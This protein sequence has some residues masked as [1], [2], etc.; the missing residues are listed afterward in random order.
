M[1]LELVPAALVHASELGR[2][3]Y[4]SFK[5]IADRHHFP[6]IFPSVDA[7]RQTIMSLASH[8]AYYGV[9]ALFDGEPAGSAFVSLEDEVA[10]IAPVSVE[11][12]RQGHSIGRAMMQHLI[13]YSRQRGF[14]RI[15]LL[16]EAYNTSSL[17][18]YASLGFDVKDA[19]V[20]MQAAPSPDP[21]EAVR[22][23]T[24]ADVPAVDEL[25]RR[26]YRVSRRQEVADVIARNAPA[27]VRERDSRITGYF[28]P[29]MSGFCV[30]ETHD[31]ALALIGEAAIRFGETAKLLCPLS[32]GELYRK[33]LKA[34]CR[35][36][37]VL[38]LMVVGPYDPPGEVWMPSGGY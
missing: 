1:T 9:A 22:P 32:E 18:L 31:D 11:V 27:L 36:I 21:Q 14:E 12:T 24:G 28:Q 26:K 34:G 7:A 15:R 35:A 20:F 4:E 38:N 23:I 16:Q 25:T 29:A 3:A 37:E 19:I 13:D 17:S 10:G 6:P 2:I 33:C 8:H 5:D 30:A